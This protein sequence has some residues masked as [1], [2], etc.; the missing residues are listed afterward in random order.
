LRKFMILK[1]VVVNAR[2]ISRAFQIPIWVP[3]IQ[4]GSLC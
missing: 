4:S 1:L 3:A 2:L